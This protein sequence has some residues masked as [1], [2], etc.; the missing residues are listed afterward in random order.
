MADQTID[1]ASVAHI[2]EREFQR[3][4]ERVARQLGW[5]TNHTYRGQVAG[6]GWRT[7]ATSRGFPDLTLVR[8]PHL[9]F[10]ECKTVKGRPT[11]DQR[12][13]IT[14][15]QGCGLHAY[16]VDPTKWLKLHQLLRDPDAVPL[17]RPSPR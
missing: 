6:G 9:M 7:T 1:P 14:R 11:A 13:W 12:R 2:T 15:L 5:V 3:E 8:A 17:P 16:I 4:I 10:L